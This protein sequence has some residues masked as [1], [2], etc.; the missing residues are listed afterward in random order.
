M[1]IRDSSKEY[2]S[3]YGK[4]NESVYADFVYVS[5]SCEQI[6]GNYFVHI[7]EEVDSHSKKDTPPSDSGAFNSESC[8]HNFEWVTVQEATAIADAV[9]AYECINCGREMCIRD[10]HRTS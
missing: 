3:E 7:Y 2:D 4:K 1:C 10:R 9:L 6:N 5:V 8:H